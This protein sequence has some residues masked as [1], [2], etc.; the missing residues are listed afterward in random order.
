VS[1]RLAPD[2]TLRPV[3]D[4]D[5]DALVRVYASTRED[6]LSQV[7]WAPGQREAFEEMQFGAQDAYW[8]EHRPDAVF[9]VI[10]LDGE[11]AGRLYVD[12]A[13][14]EIRI[15]DIALLPAFRG[16]GIGTALLQGILAEGE[17]QGVPVTIHV[18][19]QNPARALYERLGFTQ[20]STTGVYDLLERRAVGDAA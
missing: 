18:E 10:E 15:V 16:H 13:P 6:E 19:R 3:L 4:A 2:P 5:R 8:R 12:R 11:I 17:E 7:A 20:I 9:S 14:K 1:S